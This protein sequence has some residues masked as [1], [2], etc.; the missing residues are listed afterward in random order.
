MN[1]YSANFAMP[2]KSASAVVEEMPLSTAPVTN[3]VRCLAILGLSFLP[4]A[5]LRMSAS[6]MVNPASSRAA[7]ITC[8]W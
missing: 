2:S 4:I 6:L 7:I 8:S 1:P 3:F 5:A